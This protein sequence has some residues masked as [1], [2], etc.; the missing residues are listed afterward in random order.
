VDV[1]ARLARAC[2]RRRTWGTIQLCGLAIVVACTVAWLVPGHAYAQG[3]SVTLSPAPPYNDGQEITVTGSGFTS[4]IPLTGLQIIECSDPGGT[5]ANL[6]TDPLTGCDGTTING[7]QVTPDTNGNFTTT[8]GILTLSQ[9]G[10]NTINCDSTDFCVLWVGIDYNTQFLTGPHAFSEPFE[11]TTAATT[12]TTTTTTSPTTTS[13][14]TTSPTTT[15][16]TTTSPTTTSPTTTSPTT[17]TTQPSVTTTASST[18]TTSAGTTTTSAGGTTTTSESGTTSTSS[19]STTTAAGGSTT[20][21]APAAS[22]SG[23][24]GGSSGGGTV[25]TPSSQ[26]AFTGSPPILP[27][28]AA[29]GFAMSLIGLLGRRILPRPS[30]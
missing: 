12:T 13:P 17:T 5:M 30:T 16:P 15:S 2:L 26:L 22:G 14:T 6:P 23:G 10:G 7:N 8:Y 4:G 1:K 29:L 11:V 3:E 21:A 19:S 24:S 27:W 9:A 18:T 28:L 20:T 25:T